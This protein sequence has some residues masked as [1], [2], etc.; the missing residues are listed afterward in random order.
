MFAQ[1]LKELRNNY[2]LS[3]ESLAKKLGL[4]QQ[5]YGHWETGRTQPDQNTL[6]RLAN[7]FN[8]TTDY[9]LGNDQPSVLIINEPEISLE[10]L[11]LLRKL[12]KLPADKREIVDAVIKVSEASKETSA[13]AGE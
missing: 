13:V 4:A 8:V 1:R 2:G 7:F 6:I 10:D 11:E 5:T 9:L 3:Q 12:K